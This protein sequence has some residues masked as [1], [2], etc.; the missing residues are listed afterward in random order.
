MSFLRKNK[1]EDFEDEYE[2]EERPPRRI[3]DLAPKNKRKRKEPPKPWGKKE[4]YVVLGLFSLTIFTSAILAISAR[5][6]KLPGFPR[7]STDFKNFKLN[8]FKEETITIGKGTPGQKK[9]ADQIISDFES[10]TRELSGT[11][12]LY[13]IDLS[14][15]YSFGTDE[16][17]VMQA[18]SLI[19]LP[20]MLY[21]SGKVDD[22]KIEAMGKR[23]DNSV[24]MEIRNEFGDKVLQDNITSLG[25]VNTS[26]I[27]NQ[28][29]AKEIGD[30]LKKIYEDKNELILDS[31][32]GTIFE[33]WLTPGIPEGIRISH[34]Y[35]REVHVVNDAGIVYSQQPFVVVIMTQGVVEKEADQVFPE[36]SKLVYDGMTK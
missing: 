7:F 32:T 27:E 33:D 6:F 17:K 5:D 15:G 22:A 18:A 8:I 30:L 28:T 13:V 21:V 35:G 1:E 2:E 23:S 29:T 10:K 4:R 20:I 3:R 12:A 19:K 36:L 16:N 26:I 14:N 34:K 31:I 25:M 9:K 11:Y 24:F